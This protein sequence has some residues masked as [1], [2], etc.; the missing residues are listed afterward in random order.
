MPDALEV[1]RTEPLLSWPVH[2]GICLLL[3]CSAGHSTRKDKCKR[4]KTRTKSLPS[5]THSPVVE[6]IHVHT[7]IIIVFGIELN[8]V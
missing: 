3:Y 7:Q 2:I 6:K 5:G 4:D 8:R 1:K